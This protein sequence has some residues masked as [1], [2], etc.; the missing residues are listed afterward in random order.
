MASHRLLVMASVNYRE[1]GRD[2]LCLVGLVIHLLTLLLS[3]KRSVE[4]EVPGQV[5][6]QP[7]SGNCASARDPVPHLAI[8]W[9]M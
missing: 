3:Q 7:A 2:G 1:M 9:N 4:A 5:S 6:Q 8:I